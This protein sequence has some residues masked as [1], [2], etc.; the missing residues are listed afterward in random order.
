MRT[1]KWLIPVLILGAIAYA[2]F[3]GGHP[4]YRNWIVSEP[5]P[6]PTMAP[7]DLRIKVLNASGILGAG[8]DVS[9]YLSR[10]GFDLYGDSNNY[11]IVPRTR[12]ID[13]LDRQLKYAREISNAVLVPARKL[14][15]FLVQPRQTPEIGCAIDSLLYLDCTVVLGTNY[16][17]F[18]PVKPRPF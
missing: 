10:A 4:S 2:V 13:R 18:F 16:R 7:G 5:R 8:R 17:T 9:E 15:P 3:G 11:E 12:I 6:K 14:G 1:V